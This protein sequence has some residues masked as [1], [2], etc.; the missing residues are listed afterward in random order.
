MCKMRSNDKFAGRTMYVH[1]TVEKIAV[2]VVYFIITSISLGTVIS[3]YGA[4][5]DCVHTL[6]LVLIVVDQK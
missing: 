1:P 3:W 4:Y 6:F 2:P 5:V